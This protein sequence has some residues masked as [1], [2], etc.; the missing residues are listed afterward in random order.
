MVPSFDCS[1]PGAGFRPELARI[2]HL[3]AEVA[4]HA[5]VVPRD[6][7][8]VRFALFVLEDPSFSLEGCLPAD[9]PA[10]A[11]IA[12]M[13]GHL[14]AGDAVDRFAAREL[15]FEAARQQRGADVVALYVWRALESIGMA[16]YLGQDPRQRGEEHLEAGHYFAGAIAVWGIAAHS[17]R[18]LVSSRFSRIAADDEHDRR[19]SVLRAAW[20]KIVAR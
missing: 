17:Q 9:H 3:S 19:T 5:R 15:A 4:A 8:W 11:A 18:A 7:F 1:R 12:Q 10:Q 20:D 13:V 14:K 2:P 6:G 16:L